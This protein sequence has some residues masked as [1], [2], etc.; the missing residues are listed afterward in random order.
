MSIPS[1]DISQFQLGPLTIRFYALCLLAGM[2]LAW[3]IGRTRWVARGGLADTFE[4]IAIVAIPSG[5]VGA[6]IYHV[7]THWE[8]YFGEGRDPISALYIWEG[9]IAIFGAVIGGGL[10]ALFVCWRR[11]ARITAFADSLAPGLILAQAVGR[12]GNWF[13]QELFGGPD[14]GP[15]GLEIAPDRRPAEHRDVETF[16]PTFL[17]ELTWNALGCLALLWIDR[18]FQLGWGKLFALY[19]V[20]YGSGRFWIEGIRTDFSYMVGPLRTNQVTAVAFIVA[21]LLLFA[22]AHSLRKGRE[23]WVER[24]GVG[25]PDHT[26]SDHTASDHTGSDHTDPDHTDPDG[27]EPAGNDP[28]RAESSAVDEGAPPERT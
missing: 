26:D 1:P 27:A 17:Y 20:I 3:F 10:G 5:I 28:G 24:A 25:G 15:L 11:G 8:D 6:R 14:D 22:I 23:P 12:L 7:A 18:K 21:G 16:Q 9:G 19:M 2:I 4:S 13:N